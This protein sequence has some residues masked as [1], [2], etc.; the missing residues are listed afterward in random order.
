MHITNDLP[1]YLQIAHWLMAQQQWMSA[2]QVALVFN[3]SSKLACDDFAVLRL[4]KDLFTLSE[5]SQK[6]SNGYERLIKVTGI[7]AYTLDGRRCP[8]PKQDEPTSPRSMPGITWRE[9]V[10][11]PWHRLAG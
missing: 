1:R 9:L 10:A 8:H 4:R 7:H 11:R 2:R 6:C 5:T 3:I